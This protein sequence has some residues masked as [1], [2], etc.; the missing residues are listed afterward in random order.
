MNE[1]YICEDRS[2][3]LMHYGRKGM[4][5]GKHK[6]QTK[7]ELGRLAEA[8]ERNL[9]QNQR[10]SRI[11]DKYYYEHGGASVETHVAMDH[12]SRTCVNTLTNVVGA[13]FT[14]QQKSGTVGTSWL[15]ELAVSLILLILIGKQQKIIVRINAPIV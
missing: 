7:E 3:Y 14:N 11:A 2:D 5:W 10:D 6:F 8:A 12:G 1:Y 4:K 15:T 9:E 13:L